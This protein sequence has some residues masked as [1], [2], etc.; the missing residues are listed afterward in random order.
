MKVF[1]TGAT[2]Y[3]GLAVGRALVQARHQ[4]TG[5]TRSPSRRD[6]LAA[7][8][9]S[10]WVGDLR[11][12]DSYNAEA[13]K[14]EAVVHA[15]FESGPEAAV[16]ERRAVETLLA[17][18]RRGDEPRLFVYTS[19]VWVLGPR[20]DLDADETSA[21][22]PLPNV[23]WRPEVERIVLDAAG[24]SV[25]TVVLRP[26]CVYGGEGGLYGMMLASLRE[27]G[28]IPLVGDGANC[29]ASVERDD[30]AELYRRVLEKRPSRQVYHATDGSA[31]PIRDVARAFIAAA[32]GG[33]T[34]TVPLARAL[35][36][37][38]PFAEA[39]AMD[40]RVS[41]DKARREL[42]WRPQVA[43]AS[44]AAAALLEQCRLRPADH[45]IA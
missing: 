20:R 4:V 17:C 41:S 14:A 36:E 5:L 27:R 21:L 13:G 16:V 34:E 9:I 18:C 22:A 6:E 42:G 8:G 10:P 19:G 12:P 31:E 24:G 1:L 37:M 2:G 35:Q 33:K 23:A 45:P 38:G 32:G 30:L 39:L 25:S 28:V 40:Q 15:G 26:G 11:R 29:W 7:A 43:S 44:S 3:I